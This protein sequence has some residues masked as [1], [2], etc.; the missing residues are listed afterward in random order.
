M[1]NSTC[2]T[3]LLAM[4]TSIASYGQYT[5]PDCFDVYDQA[6]APFSQGGQASLDGVNYEAKYWVDTP[7]PGEAWNN[8]GPCGDASGILGDPFPEKRKVIGYMPTWQSSYD[9]SDY[10]PSKLSHVIVSFLDFKAVDVG[11]VYD[12]MDYTSDDFVS[13]IVFSEKSV[14]AVDSLLTHSTTNLLSVSHAADTKVMV[15]I[16][17]AIDY[18][19]L[20]LMN[21]YYNDD[22]KITEI[23]QLMVNYVESR[24]IDGIDLDMECWWIDNSINKTVDEGGRIRGSNFGAPDDGP[25]VA[26]IGITN[27]A[28]KIKELKP[29]IILSSVVFGTGWYGNNYDEAMAEYLDWIG[30]FTYD[31]TGSW[32]ETPFGPHGALRKLPLNSYPSQTADNPIYSAEEILEY[33]M[34][35]ATP[36]WNH[37][38]GF[39]IERN[40]L[41]IGAPFYGYDFSTPKPNGGNGYEF[42]KY[43]DI[44]A[45]YPNAPISYDPLSP[46]DFNG[47]INQDGEIL[48]YETPMRIR[49]KMEFVYDYGHQGI[50]I[51]EL[52][53]DLHPTHQ[54]SLLNNIADENDIQC[55]EAALCDTLSVDSM[56]EVDDAAKLYFN[57][58]SI[59]YDFTQLLNHPQNIE[60]FDLTGRKVMTHKVTVDKGDFPF[61]SSNGIYIIKGEGLS[62]LIY[63]Y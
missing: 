15:A 24:G 53:T 10:D 50:I 28:R 16:G 52:T 33:W 29:D 41:C 46:G 56:S 25:H 58:N 63:V 7:P 18:G 32:D 42:E 59:H 26:G 11:D 35:I 43:A 22:Q 57:D 21:R 5:F 13:D 62:K 19:F 34:G 12:N 23:A 60:I 27:L 20:W 54:Y 48:Y 61:N 8:L 44:V 49:D 37:D 55:A 38:G 17:G 39:D 1:R 40:K 4:I 9:F 3:I 14:T 30:I 45:K 2:I 31:L 36:V 6:N 51:W 47:H